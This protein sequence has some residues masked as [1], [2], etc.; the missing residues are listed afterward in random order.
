M[1]NVLFLVR[2][3]PGSGKTTLAHLLA[4]NVCSADD[5]FT[6]ITDQYIFKASEL[7]NAHADCQSRVAG[8]LAFG[9]SRVAVANTFT[10]E[11]E[12]EP[13]FNLAKEYGYMVQTIVVE[14]RH[15]GEN[16]HDVPVKAIDR[17]RTR[18]SIK[19]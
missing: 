3:L 5:Y 11:W 18:F 16:I 17:M 1:E 10:Q 8:M 7:K 2:G 6:T 15:G 19:L 13:Y 14:N 12:M 9:L 4:T